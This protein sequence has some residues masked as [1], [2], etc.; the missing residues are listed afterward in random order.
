[1]DDATSSNYMT[2]VKACTQLYGF[3]QPRIYIVPRTDLKTNVM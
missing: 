3:F 1:M 2:N